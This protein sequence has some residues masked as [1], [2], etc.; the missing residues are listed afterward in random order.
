MK[1]NLGKLI[2]AVSVVGKFVAVV[3]HRFKGEKTGAEKKAAVIESVREALPMIE[4]AL[5]R[6]LLTDAAFNQALNTLIDAEKAVL[7]ARDAFQSLIDDAKR[8]R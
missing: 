1:L 4:D 6:D 8:P 3:Q 5:D 2:G 7:K